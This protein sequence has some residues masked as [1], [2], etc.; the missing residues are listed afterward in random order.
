[1]VTRLLE[2][3]ITR[4][5]LAMRNLS[6]RLLLLT[7]AFVMLAEILILVPTIAKFRVDWLMDRL[8]AAQIAALALQA[9][10]N[11]QLPETLEKELLR[12]TGVHSIAIKRPHT[13]LMALQS[14]MP[15]VIDAE[16]RLVKGWSIAQII[17]GLAIFFQ[18]DDRVIRVTGQPDM[19][20]RDLM[21]IVIEE[22]PLK[23]AIYSHVGRILLLSGFIS[24]FTATL[25]YL[26]LNR[27][28][29]RPMTRL[30]SNIMHFAENPEDRSRVITPEDRN[31][32][33]G[34]AERAL[35]RL[36]TQLGD[37]LH[38]KN[39][40][41]M[42]GL[43]VSKINH[44]LRN[45]L[46]STQLISDRIANVSDPLAKKLAPKLLQSLDRAID[47]CSNTL[48]YGRAQEPAPQREVFPLAPLVDEIAEGLGMEER[49]DVRLEN[50][51]PEGLEVDADRNQLYRVLANLTRNA[52]EA[53]EAV[54]AKRQQDGTNLQ[55]QGLIRISAQRMGSAVTIWVSDTGPGLP[56]RARAHLFEPFQGSGRKGGTGLGLAISAELLHAHGGTIRLKSTGAHGTSFELTL[57][58]QNNSPARKPPANGNNA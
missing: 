54:A 21:E 6:N 39:R 11:H 40:L 32:V 27:L 18:P 38:Q 56:E 14:N 57:P 15:A 41:A 36:Q 13:R 55:V 49:P 7:I 52:V 20:T 2:T 22:A 50:A 31:D 37:M 28:L 47:L 8:A 19:G 46:A 43:A 58:D 34:D 53:I 42:L 5:R 16:Y 3:T 12:K 9:S 26:S 25:I 23:T 44:D 29:V 30:I 4:L 17:D 48:K 45:I 35:A 51:V 1:M 33:I 24:L 10:P